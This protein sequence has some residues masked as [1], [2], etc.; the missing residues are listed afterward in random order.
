MNKK[1]YIVYCH[2]LN[3][4]KYIGYTEK[5]I[6][7]RLSEHIKSA[8][9]KSQ[10]YFHR[11]IRK[12]GFKNIKS[13][14]LYT[15]KQKKRAIDKEVYYI[16]TFKTTNNKY[17]Y[18]MTY[19]GDGGN[20]TKHLS[21]FKRKKWIEKL[22]KNTFGPNNPKYSGY[23]DNDLID[24]GVK[25]FC[26]YKSLG[27]I[28]WRAYCKNNGL[29]QSFSKNRFNGSFKCF[30]ELVK[31][32]LNKLNIP[33]NENDFNNSSNTYSEKT[34]L[35]IKAAITGRKWFNDGKRNYQIFEHDTRILKLNLQRGR[36]SC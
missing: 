18:N 36:I 32:K 34:R 25:Y 10:N 17:G 33:F 6:N 4:K 35:K 20:C 14:I 21:S 9:N 11:A 2:T 1:T 12:Y 24:I 28:E 8:N 15:T 3:N 27:V 13:E 29:P 30:V 23:S 19:G 5:D 22:S 31:E 26:C 16:K 7:T